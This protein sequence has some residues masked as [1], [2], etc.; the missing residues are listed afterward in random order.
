MTVCGEE[1]KKLL[2]IQVSC[3]IKYTKLKE[4]LRFK[5]WVISFKS[6]KKITFKIQNVKKVTKVNQLS[7]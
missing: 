1:L 7:V 6:E 4:G 3:V 2:R 5:S